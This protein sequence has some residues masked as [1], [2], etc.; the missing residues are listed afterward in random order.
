MFF[1]CI[2]VYTTGLVVVVGF[3]SSTGVGGDN[4]RGCNSI[5]SRKPVWH[6]TVRRSCVC[7]TSLDAAV[8]SRFSSCIAGGAPPHPRGGGRVTQTWRGCVV[9]CSQVFFS[10][11]RFFSSLPMGWGGHTNGFLDYCFVWKAPARGSDR[12]IHVLVCQGYMERASGGGL[13]GGGGRSRI[14]MLV[15]GLAV[16]EQAPVLSDFRLRGEFWVPPP[17][18]PTPLAD[19]ESAAVATHQRR[20]LVFSCSH[21]PLAVAVATHLLLLPAA[22]VGRVLCERS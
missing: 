10:F 8:H 5:I 9:H 14:I 12:F 20:N 15:L 19:L 17:C 21:V 18:C 16:R 1:F 13:V 6:F 22:L 7:R 4:G 3:V 11:F 2:W